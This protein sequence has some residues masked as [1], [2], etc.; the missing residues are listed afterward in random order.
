MKKI[1]LPIIA[2]LLL[3]SVTG[4]VLDQKPA[5]QAEVKSVE[6]RKPVVATPEIA[7]FTR[8]ELLEG[9]NAKRASEGK[10][11]LTIN[12]QLNESAQLKANDMG[13]KQYWSHNAPD[14]TEPWADFKKVGYDYKHAGE[15]LAKCYSTTEKAVEAWWNSPA[16]KEN[17]LGDFKE[18]GFGFVQYKQD[19]VV[20]VQHFGSR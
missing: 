8:T 14:G 17:M 11:P 5:P 3:A 10:A 20:I 12:A 7:P 18:T 15:N 19:C 9:V 2:L 16:H 1:F 13:E 6:V 4:F